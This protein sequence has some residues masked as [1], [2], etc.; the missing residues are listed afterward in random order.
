MMRCFISAKADNILL[1]YLQELGYDMI[2]IEESDYVGKEVSTHPDMFMTKLG[3]EPEAPIFFGNVKELGKKYPKDVRFNAAICG[4]YLIGNQK[5]VSPAL[6]ESFTKALNKWIGED[7]IFVDVPQ[8]YT[9]CNLVVVDD[10]HVITE[11]EGIAKVLEG[12]E[13]IE[14]LLV[15]PGHVQLDGYPRGF[16]GG[17]SGRICY[18]RIMFNG[19]IEKHP[20]FQKIHDFITSCGIGIISIDDYPLTDIGSI[21]TFESYEGKQADEV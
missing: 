12:I 19:D 13:D 3:A 11:D 14:C 2:L 1:D 15:E 8:G 4:K 17:A 20:D 9:K 16:L 6:K 18:D 5:N 21:I 7:P 10:G